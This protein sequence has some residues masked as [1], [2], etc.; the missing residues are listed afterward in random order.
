KAAAL[1]RPRPITDR[2]ARARERL[3]NLEDRTS[4]CG[5]VHLTKD[6]ARVDALARILESISYRAVLERGFALVK[7]A[8][9]KLRRRAA[10]IKPGE[11]LR[12]TFADGERGVLAEAAPKPRGKTPGG[13]QGSLF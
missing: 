5:R 6:R 2:I 1:L 13:D 9:G 8:D 11:S 3:T 12:L 10:Q 4:R 7:G